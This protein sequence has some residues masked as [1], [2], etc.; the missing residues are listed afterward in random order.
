MLPV[1]GAG[2]V[3]G[4]MAMLDGRPLP[5][6][7]L[8]STELMVF[9]PR[10]SLFGGNGRVVRRFT[11]EER[12]RNALTVFVPGVGQ[13]LPTTLWVRERPNPAPGTDALDPI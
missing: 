10:I 11:L 12:Q 13:S 8:N 2:F 6:A 5:T 9:I 4:A 3:P 1:T 7:F